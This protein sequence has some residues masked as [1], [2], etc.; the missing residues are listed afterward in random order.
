MPPL[1]VNIGG[2]PRQAEL[3]S[4]LDFAQAELDD[5]RRRAIADEVSRRGLIA[6]P[7][8]QAIIDE[9]NRRG[10]LVGASKPTSLPELTGGFVNRPAF[11]AA[12]GMTG[13]VLGGASGLVVGTPGGPAG[14]AT[15]GV[16]GA[17]AGG[18]LG[19]GLG[20][21]AFDATT[22]LADILGFIEADVPTPVEQFKRAGRSAQ[23]DAAFGVGGQA[24]GVT[25][26]AVK[27]LV[28]RAL[29]VRGE[30]AQDMIDAAM[31][32]GIEVGAI[33]VAPGF[34]S[35]LLRGSSRV[36]GIF[37]WIG[38]PFRRAATEKSALID[39]RV[40]GMLDSMAP[41]ATMTGDLGLDMAQAARSSIKQFR[42]T[43]ALLYE[44]FTRLAKDSGPIVP[45]NFSDKATISI[46]KAAE[47]LGDAR[48]TGET[49]LNPS[50]EM[51]ERHAKAVDVYDLKRLQLDQAATRAQAIKDPVKQA[52]A[53]ELIAARER[54]LG[55][56]PELG[57][58]VLKSPFS[59]R[60]GDFIEQFSRLPDRITVPQLRKL[61]TDMSDFV[62]KAKAEGFDV[63]R[64][65]DLKKSMEGAL[66]NLDLS[67][68]PQGVDG[69]LI[70]SAID[71]ANMYYSK[72]IIQFQSPTGKQFGKFD[73]N[74]FAP[75]PFRASTLNEDEI[76]DVAL[77]LKSKQGVDTL[78]T[79]VGDDIM[80]KAARRHLEKAWDGVPITDKGGDPVGF[81]W[82]KLKDELGITGKNKNKEAVRALLKGSGTELDELAE[83]INVASKIEVPASMSQFLAR[84]ASIGGFGTMMAAATASGLVGDAAGLGSSIAVALLARYGAK[85]IAD[86][87][88][89]RM[90]RR[91]LS[92]NT[93]Q[94]QVRALVARMFRIAGELEEEQNTAF[95]RTGQTP[96]PPAAIQAVRQGA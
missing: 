57:E 70:K 83:L 44:N 33:D 55:A 52:D 19:S 91:V 58:Q 60:L 34:R 21:I 29:G 23:E 45:T 75:G 96:P 12:G 63:S 62:D 77:N 32:Q 72:G 81:D 67:K 84:R 48:R 47:G 89:L 5:D 13:S 26:R 51:L 56:P 25:A 76:A 73:R 24:I 42:D 66:A 46:K 7:D 93:P 43:A 65:M 50:K 64:F 92:P 38:G 41:N 80:N 68:L 27:P 90:M 17:T 8:R 82:K 36:L 94:I 3:G 69:K 2:R 39:Q 10:L 35:R 40:T 20:S 54:V 14:V 1:E 87:Q 85:I 49:I 22:S 88:Q 4:R 86:P 61:S 11:E 15:A 37:P 28:G 30:I 59:D 9:L 74:V 16:V 31:R 78:R 6:R 53:F 95:V 18:A 71:T 79:L